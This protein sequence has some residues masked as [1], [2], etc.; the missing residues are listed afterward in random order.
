MS[1]IRAPYFPRWYAFALIAAVFL[2]AAATAFD[3]AGRVANPV[4]T[5]D[6]WYFLDVFVAPDVNGELTWRD[7]FLKR[8]TARSR[9]GCAPSLWVWRGR[10]S[11]CRLRNPR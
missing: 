4:V 2:L 3:Y 9:T 11:G 10:V 8:D 6:A 1:E 7:F 5:A